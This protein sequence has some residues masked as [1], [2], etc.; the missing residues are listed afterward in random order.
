LDYEYF[1]QRVV[2]TLLGRQAVPNIVEMIEDLIAHI[3][4]PIKLTRKTLTAI[5]TRTKN[6]QAAL[7]NPQ[8]FALQAARIVRE[9]AVQQ[10]VDGIQYYKDGTWYDM[11]EWV[12]EEETVS[13]RLIPVDNS[14][15]DY[16]VVQSEAEK[17]FAERLKKMKNVRLFV[18]LPNWFK[19]GTPVGQ[20]NPDWGLV[21]EQVFGEDGPMLYLVRETKSTTVA[22]ALRGTENLKTHCGERHFQGALGV[23]YKVITPTDDLP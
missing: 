11:S 7:D 8:E 19:V 15:Y 6:R 23:N 10:L 9:K 20:Y 12:E 17:K 1:G 21:M 22:D 4:P 3:T 13:E 14:I 18:K 2:A 5:V 16:I